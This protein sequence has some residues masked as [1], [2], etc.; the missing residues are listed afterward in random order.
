MLKLQA[1]QPSELNIVNVSDTDQGFETEFDGF[2]WTLNPTVL[3]SQ[4]LN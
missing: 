4:S 2:Q 1:I 3:T